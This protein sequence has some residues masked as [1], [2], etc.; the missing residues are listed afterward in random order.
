[1]IWLSI[2]LSWIWWIYLGTHVHMVLAQD[3]LVYETLGRNIADQGFFPNFFVQGPNREPIYPLMVAFAMKMAFWYRIPF[4][5]IMI[6]F[7]I[8]ILGLNQL[9]LLRLLQILKIRTSIIALSL[10]Y[11]GFS[12][13]INN[14]ALSLYSEISAITFILPL[15]LI[16]YYVYENVRNDAKIPSMISALGIGV[17]VNYLTLVKAPFEIITPVFLSALYVLLWRAY[18][19]KVRLISICAAISFSIFIGFIHHY[20]SLNQYY[21]GQYALTNRASWAL[22]GNTARRMEPLNGTRLLGAMA[23]VPGDGVCK[24]F[25]DADTCDFWSFRMSDEIGMTKIS[26]LQKF[27]KDADA[28]NQALVRDAAHMA[29]SNPLQYAFLTCLE[30]T[31]MFFWESTQI[32]FVNYPTWLNHIYNNEMFKDALRLVVALVTIFAVGFVWVLS[33]RKTTEP[34]VRLMGLLIFLWIGTY[35]FFFIVTR[36]ALPIAS[37]FII[38]IAYTANILYNNRHAKH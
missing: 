11:L 24:R 35:A 9:C 36:Y 20:K 16:T 28:T 25:I 33:F 29:L 4:E 10:L 2:A 3:A 37:L 19:T 1:M 14:A 22:Y 8:V 13:S 21:N 34:V 5:N 31:K 12:P 26:A 15:L 38:A 6:T 23:Y 7:G 27:N 18:P 17:A 30:G 32:G